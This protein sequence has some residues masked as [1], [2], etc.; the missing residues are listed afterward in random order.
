MK[1][2]L[3]KI[4]DDMWSKLVLIIGDLMLD[5]FIWG[6][7]S[8]ISAEA[9]VPI[10]NVEKVTYVPGGSGNTANNVASLAGRAIAVGVVG[11]DS[12]G[13]ILLNE[14]KIRNIS[15]D[16]IFKDDT[17]HTIEKTR[18]MGESQHLLRYDYEENSYISNNVEAKINDYLS[19][20]VADVNAVI[21][22]DYAKG[23]ITEKLA[24]HLVNLCNK[25]DKVIIVDTKP[26]HS[27]FYKNVT[28][29]KPNIKEAIEMSGEHDLIKAGGKLKKY[30]DAN[31]LI[32]RGKDGM[33]LF[34]KNGDYIEMPT[35]AR[36]V[37]DVSGAG[38]TVMATIGSALGTR[39]S[40]EDAVHLAN[41][42]AGI[43]VEKRGVVPVTMEELKNQLKIP[44]Y[45]KVWGEE[46]WLVNE[47][48][49]GKLLRLN[50]GFKSSLHYHKNKD[51][52]FY[53]T[54]GKVLLELTKDRI[55][56]NPGDLQR[57]RPGQIH[58]FSGLEDSEIIE[59]STHHEEEDSYRIEKSGKME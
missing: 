59:F 7:I 10:V 24:R 14:L 29:V 1:K 20:Q 38:D 25:Y 55:I 45:P 58:R 40:L 48:Y 9:P 3:E 6:S 15:I 17:K 37:Y 28:L 42:A 23:S 2:S 26:K 12:A 54:K 22:S 34:L 21:I 30:F 11:D 49:C 41:I 27:R 36:E 52:T 47:D 51:E 16:G 43:V 53:V 32:T 8:R 56:M 57:I 18:I 31:I 35:R 50:K 13:D 19:G 39:S 44:F 46:R 33:S 4:I 5:K